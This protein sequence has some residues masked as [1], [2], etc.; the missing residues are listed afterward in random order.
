MRDGL[1]PSN[2]LASPRIESRSPSFYSPS[3]LCKN[4]PWL[5]EQNSKRSLLSVSTTRE[6]GQDGC[7]T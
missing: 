1:A 3:F 5:V 7:V 2:S 6:D 4:D